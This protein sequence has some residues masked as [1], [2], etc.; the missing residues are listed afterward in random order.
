MKCANG[1]TTDSPKGWTRKE[2]K[3]YGIE[4][5][6]PRGWLKIIEQIENGQ[7]PTKT[8]SVKLVFECSGCLDLGFITAEIWKNGART[9]PCPGCSC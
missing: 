1:L 8:Q 3:K 4:W 2:L 5:P 6:P 7:N 9:I